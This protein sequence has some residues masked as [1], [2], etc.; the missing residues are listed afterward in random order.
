MSLREAE[1]TGLEWVQTTFSLEPR[2]TV[3]PD[4]DS[5]R[6]TIESLLPGREFAISFL[7]Q[8]A[9]NKIY[10]I[11]ADNKA[12]I[13][14]VSL[15]VDL[16]HKTLSEVATIGWTRRHTSLPVPELIAHNATRDNPI[17]FEWI[18]ME[19]LP[20]K[21][22]ESTWVGMEFSAKERLVKKLASYYADTFGNQLRGIG[23]IYPGAS[24]PVQ[25]GESP[26]Q[27]EEPP[28]VQRIVSIQF[29][30][31]DHIQQDVPRGPFKSSGEWISAYL[32]L[33]ENDCRSTLAKHESGD[34]S[35]RDDDEVEDAQRT[36][37]IITRLK[38][39]VSDFFP[40]CGQ[41]SEF[42]VLLHDDLSQHNILVDEGGSLTGVVDWEFVS[43]LPLWK[44]CAYPSF[45]EGR[46]RVDAPDQATY[47]RGDD[48]EPDSLY[49]EHL[50]EYELTKLRSCFLGEMRRLAPEWVEVFD[51][52]VS[53]R[54]FYLAVQNCDNE[55]CSRDII[56]WLDD[57]AT[58][59]G[60]IRS[61][62]D[63][64]DES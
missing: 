18:L 7:T 11:A 36:L 1:L 22:L 6:R 23:N 59:H 17:G 12:L 5:I 40:Y 42:S 43:A 25:D 32:S 47:Q 39:S 58:G 60:E 51:S 52:A 21:P 48:G 37:D 30:W 29:F 9:F 46:P 61:L 34:D 20:G 41:D 19:K 28:A 14:R 27:D 49:W 57:V 63:R 64:F 54:D 50:R 3:D 55:F 53:K 4:I 13:L 10:D 2:W 45:L 16:G 24:S 31:G 56:T 35:T 33:S 62:R 44:A 26:V 38:S 15:P 8:G